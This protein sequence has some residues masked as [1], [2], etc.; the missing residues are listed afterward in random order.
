MVLLSSLKIWAS[1]YRQTNQKMSKLSIAYPSQFKSGSQNDH[2]K[3]IFMI[4]R[5]KKS[6]FRFSTG[7]LLT[8]Q[9]LLR[10]R[11][12]CY[13]FQS[14]HALFYLPVIFFKRL[15]KK[16]EDVGYQSRKRA[17]FCGPNLAWTLK[18]K[19]K[20]DLNPNLLQP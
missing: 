12:S 4:F 18:W 17:D 8:M 14:F 2:E 20:P 11:I 7:D 15:Q 9:Y 5:A 10:N 6:Y 13:L 1:S 3:R 19:S 16:W